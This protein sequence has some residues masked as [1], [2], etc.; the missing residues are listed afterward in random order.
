MKLLIQTPTDKCILPSEVMDD[1]PLVCGT[2]FFMDYAKAD[3]KNLETYLKK[4]PELK[5]KL[6]PEELNEVEH[7]YFKRLSLR[8]DTFEGEEWTPLIGGAG[9]YEISNIGRVKRVSTTKENGGKDWEGRILK[10][11]SHKG[12]YGTMCCVNNT[13]FQFRIHRQLAIQFIPNPQGLP[14]VNHKN[15]I[16][17]DCRLTNLEW[18]DNSHNQIHSFKENK[19]EHVAGMLGKTG[20][21]CKNSLAVLQYTLSGEYIA[22][23]GSAAEAGRVMGIAQSCI[24]V[25]VRTGKTSLG[26][27]WKYKNPELRRGAL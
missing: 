11:R 12:Y 3:K 21:A 10:Q 26:F 9:L 25:A 17:Y 4:L 20:H 13:T 2:L 8:Y 15:G 23:Y 27:Y 19:R 18:C 5:A 24:S 7:Y 14:Q 16:R 1:Q 6:S 22:E